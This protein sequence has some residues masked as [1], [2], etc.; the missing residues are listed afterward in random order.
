MSFEISSRFVVFDGFNLIA[1][2]ELNLVA[3]AASAYG[4]A[5]PE[6]TLVV[7]DLETGSA[8]DLDLRGTP[9]EVVSRLPP[10]GAVSEN[11]DASKAP[12]RGRPRLGVIAREVTL[13]P[14]HWE[15]LAGQRGGASIALRRLVDEAKQ[16]TAEAD[17]H[18]RRLE[19]AYQALTT[20][21]GDLPGYESAIRALF[22]SDRDAFQAAT[23]GWSSDLQRICTWLWPIKVGIE[24]THK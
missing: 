18:R 20:L 21:A 2:G 19:A 22:A 7:L 8:V 5:K 3:A 23:A 1:D 13:L 4:T 12:V 9:H 17:N 16:R 11:T 15:W 24:G 10:P 6:A 14:R